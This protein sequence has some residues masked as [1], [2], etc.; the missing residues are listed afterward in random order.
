MWFDKKNP[1]A[2]FVD[3]RSLARREIWR[4]ADGES[5]SFEVS[6]DMQAD[7]RKLPLDDESFSLVV[8]DPP[9]LKKRN[10]KTGWMQTKYGSLGCAWRDDLRLGFSECFRVLKTGGTLIL[11]WSEAEI[12][13]SAVL[14]LTP[15]PPLFGHRTGKTQGTHW[16]AFLK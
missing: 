14:A 11:K 9:H 10:G 5:H 16:V 13:L 12:K 3:V 2:L 4:G 15:Q 8:F 7:F 6:P 1:E